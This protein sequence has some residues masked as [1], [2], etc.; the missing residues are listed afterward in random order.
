M[1]QTGATA[2]LECPKGTYAP[3]A[4]GATQCE[5]CTPGKYAAGPAA[6]FCT[7]C[8]GENEYQ[9]QSGQDA[10]LQCPAGYRIKSVG[11]RVASASGYDQ[12][13]TVS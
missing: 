12:V 9:P 1:D 2:C 7:A 10:C 6:V 11:E 13:C 8:S 5:P 3:S 4:G